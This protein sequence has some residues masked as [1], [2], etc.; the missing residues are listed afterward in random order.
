MSDKCARAGAELLWNE[1]RR[2]RKCSS[3]E[4][5]YNFLG[6]PSSLSL[7]LIG[8]NSSPPKAEVIDAPEVEEM[9]KNRHFCAAWREGK[10]ANRKLPRASG[11]ELPTPHERGHSIFTYHAASLA[12]CE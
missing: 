11:S 3:T 10:A 8:S 2:R 4:D 7:T 1:G 6:P 9:M 5:V 12:R